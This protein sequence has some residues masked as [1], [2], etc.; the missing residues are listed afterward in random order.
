MNKLFL[1]LIIFYGCGSFSKIEN[2]RQVSKRQNLANDLFFLGEKYR[3][4]KNYSLSLEKYLL[5]NEIYRSK[6]DYSNEAKTLG[7]IGYVFSKLKNRQGIQNTVKRLKDISGNFN[8]SDEL[9]DSIKIR[10]S[11][12]FKEKIK[13]KALI[14]ETLNRSTGIKK[15]YYEALYIDA[16]GFD[17][18]HI[19]NLILWNKNNQILY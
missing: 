6:F 14:L 16:I 7:K 8:K 5:A 19:K 9:I 11:I 4:E 17:E 12:E 15:Y 18:N 10:E 1:F 13:A 2:F 3:R